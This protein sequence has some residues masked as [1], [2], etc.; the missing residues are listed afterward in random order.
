MRNIFESETLRLDDTHRM[1]F[2]RFIE[3]ADNHIKFY[4]TENI[5][6]PNKRLMTQKRKCLNNKKK[7]FFFEMRD[8]KIK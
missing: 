1:L 3:T 5:K 7:H 8:K 4:Q 6:H 2:H